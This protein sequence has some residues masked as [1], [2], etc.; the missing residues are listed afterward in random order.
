M[1]SHRDRLA[2]RR[3]GADGGVETADRP[4]NVDS[5]AS[6]EGWRAH[7]ALLER[8]RL[9]GRVLVGP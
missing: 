1:S 7:L 6:F 2:D 3:A 5:D 4:L 9:E 8:L